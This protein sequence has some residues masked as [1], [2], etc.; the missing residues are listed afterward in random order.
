MQPTDSVAISVNG[1]PYVGDGN[2]SLP[3]V[4]E[5]HGVDVERTHGV[6]VAVN[7]EV[8][9]RKDW[10]LRYLE[11]GDRVEIVTARQGG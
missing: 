5:E 2:L 3:E 10:A 7:E 6:A 11:S 8:V 4:L 9:R 1:K